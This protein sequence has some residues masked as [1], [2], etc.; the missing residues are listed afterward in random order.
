MSEYDNGILK[1]LDKKL[2]CL[3]RNEILRSLE[4][5]TIIPKQ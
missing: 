3:D 2:I 4:S 1:C 5:F